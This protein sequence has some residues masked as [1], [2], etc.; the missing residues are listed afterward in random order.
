MVVQEA[1]GVLDNDIYN[2]IPDST[3]NDISKSQSLDER[4]I[5]NAEVEIP[6]Y[7]KQL[8][9]SKEHMLS[10]ANMYQQDYLDKVEE[11]Y[12]ILPVPCFK[13]LMIYSSIV[14][15]EMFGRSS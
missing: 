7:R 2:D 4:L 6:Q 13:C 9:E 14:L 8:L 1:D 10:C 3:P 5:N 15:A 11:R 12:S